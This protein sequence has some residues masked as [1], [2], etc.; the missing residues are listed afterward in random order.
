MAT[1]IG[2]IMNSKCQQTLIIPITVRGFFAKK[3]HLSRECLSF[4]LK[5]WIIAAESIVHFLR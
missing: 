2:L 3:I 5:G 1:F 4:N